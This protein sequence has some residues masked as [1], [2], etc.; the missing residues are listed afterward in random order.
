MLR[1]TGAAEQ[2]VVLVPSIEELVAL[3]DDGAGACAGMRP[4]VVLP[5]DGAIV[6]RVGACCKCACSHCKLLSSRPPQA[7]RGSLHVF[8]GGQRRCGRVLQQRLAARRAA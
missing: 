1:C 5:D 8:H 4:V 6:G 3:A 7:V 2:R